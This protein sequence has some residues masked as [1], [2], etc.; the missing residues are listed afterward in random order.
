MTESVSLFDVEIDGLSASQKVS[1]DR[2]MAGEDP[3][4]ILGIGDRELEKVYA[5][6]HQ[7]YASGQYRQALPLL[8]FVCTYQ[9]G[10]PR[11]WLALG[12]CRQM[13]KDFEGAITAYG[14]CYALNSQDPWPLIHT[15]LCC[16]AKRDNEKAR[17][18]LLLAEQTN[19]TARKDQAVAERI[20]ALRSCLS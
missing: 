17:D 3:K 8:T 18:A 5:S 6:G 15:A 11:Y 19:D 13:M 1:L 4:T 12:A 7:L 16:L 2:L 14:L 9:F 10:E 20:T